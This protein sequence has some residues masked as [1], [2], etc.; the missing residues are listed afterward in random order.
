MDMTSPTFSIRRA[1]RALGLAFVAGMF[2]FAPAAWAQQAFPT[3]DA[4]ADAF[5]DGVARQDSD[6]MSAVLGTNWRKYL[7]S[8]GVSMPDVYDFLEAWAKSHRIVPTGDA[9]AHLEVGR[10]GWTVP[11]PIVKTSA[12]WRFDTTGTPDELR[13][14]RIGRN[15]LAVVQVLLAYT[16]AQQ[17]Y[18]TNDR[19]RDGKKQF[20]RKII[21]TSGKRDGLYWPTLDGE[22]PS[23][24]GPV[25]A[26]TKP[27]EAFHGYRYRILTAQ[28]SH[29]PDGAK[30]YIQGG[31][32]SGGYAM[33]AWP[34]KYGDTGVMSFIVS[35]AGKVYQKNLGPN[36]DAVARAMT[37]F[38]PDPTWEKASP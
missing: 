26:D 5:V 4:A 9:R 13:T 20:A 32:M 6:A 16:D 34:A 7:P 29:A 36:T 37:R 28:G 11:I 23:P 1:T 38:D 17:D 14:R 27:G 2:T 10:N 3:P 18:A 33:V 30:D 35:G 15:E 25:M 22:A 19:D 21:S 24:L 8:G 31:V 12:G